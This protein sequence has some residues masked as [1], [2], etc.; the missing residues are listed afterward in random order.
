MKEAIS[1]EGI[2]SVR[3]AIHIHEIQNKNSLH[4]Q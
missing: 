4:A 3:D 1:I 2:H